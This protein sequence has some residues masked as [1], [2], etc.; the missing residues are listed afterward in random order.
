MYVNALPFAIYITFIPLVILTIYYSGWFTLLIVLYVL[1]V[2]PILDLLVGTSTRNMDIATSDQELFIHKLVTWLWVPLQFVFLVTIIASIGMSPSNYNSWEIV[3]LSISLGFMTGGIGITYAHELMHQNNK[4]EKALSEVLMTMTLYGHFCIEHIYGHHKNVGTPKD[5]V[6][7]RK[8][9]NFFSFYL[10]A[11]IG[12]FFS[13]IKI[14]KKRMKKRGRNFIHI[15]NPFWRY[16]AA[17]IIYI[18]ICYS[19]AG[20]IGVG[21]FFLQAIVAF[22]LLELINYVEHYGLSRRRD[23]NG[24]FERVQSYHSWNASYLIT[25]LFLINLQRHSDH[26]IH[27]LRRYPTLQHYE[28]DQAPQLPFSYPTILVLALFPP[29]W[30]KVVNPLVNKWEQLHY[31]DEIGSKIDTIK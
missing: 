9:E 2:I 17:Y 22:S 5:P 30:F 10:H 14:Q 4:F 20:W 8:G 6:S 24:K 7:A 1:I 23:K 21:I 31:P 26:H 3:G 15:S 18:L 19:L 11:V 29:L 16:G 27:P 13:A 25:N 28:E 12:S